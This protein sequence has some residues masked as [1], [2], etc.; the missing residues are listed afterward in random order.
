MGFFYL[1]SVIDLKSDVS[2]GTLVCFYM[3]FYVEIALC[4]I[5]YC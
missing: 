2:S 1:F 3:K 5:F 4:Y